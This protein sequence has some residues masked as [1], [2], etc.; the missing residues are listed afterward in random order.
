MAKLSRPRPAGVHARERLFQRLDECLEHRA[1]WVTGSA[2]AGK[3]TLI[4]SYVK[5][6]ELPALWYQVDSGDTDPAACCHY[7]KMVASRIAP[8]LAGE[9]PAL[10]AAQTP[11]MASFFRHFFR[12][13]YA[14]IGGQRFLVMDNAQE[15]L[16]AGTFRE[17]LL[18]AMHEA[19]D[20]LR[21]IVISRSLPPRDF[22]RLQANGDLA[23]LEGDELAFTEAE[24][25]AVQKLGTPAS[26]V[27][28]VEQMRKLHQLTRG[29][30][31]G[32]KLLLQVDDPD[33]VCATSGKVMGGTALFDYLA[34]EVFDRQSSSVRNFLLKVAHLPR[35]TAAMAD[36]L[37]HSDDAARILDGMY[38]DNL[39]TT[40][41]A[42]GAETHYEFHPL[43]RRFLLQRA[44]SDLPAADLAHVRRQAGALLAGSG[45]LDAAAQVL[46]SGCQWDDLQRL[47]TEH[48]PS[49][50]TRGWQRT[51]SAWLQALPQDRLAGD[52][53]FC[54]W[55]GA[56]LAPFDPPAAQV[57]LQ[58]AYQLFRERRLA[59]GCFFSW[60]AIVDLICLEWRDFSKLDYW[61]DE[62]ESLQ[63]EF[64][65]PVE[66]LHGR[67][68]ASIFSALLFRRPQDPAIH[69]WADR[70]LSV[71]EQCPDPHDRILLGCN[72]VLHYDVATGQNAQLDRLMAAID[73][74][75][76]IALTPLVGALFWGLKAMQ[77]W[78]HGQLV[79]AAA[80]AENGSRLACAN[81]LRMWDFLLGALQAYAW[82]NSGEL[83]QGRAALARL[84]KSLD[85]RRKIDVAHYHYLGCLASLLA[86]EGVQALKEI[87]NA[88]AIALVHGGPQQHALG[89]LAQAQALHALGRTDEAWPFLVRGREIGVSMRGKLICFQAD[90]CEAAF[91]L[92]EG[93]HD[94]CAKALHSAFATGAA[95]NYVNH[96]TFRP[97][98]VAR[99]CAFALAHGIEPDYTRRLIRIRDLKPPSLEADGWPWAIK[100][101]TLGRFSLVVD[102]QPVTE[103][104]RRQ[105]KPIELLQALIALGGRQI[106]IP[107][108]IESLWPDAE[109][110]GGR[111]A[112]DV[113]LSRLRH[114]LGHDDVLLLESGRVTLNPALCWVDVWAFERLLNQTRVALDGDQ[115]LDV[116]VLVEQTGA[117]LRLYQGDF[118]GREECHPWTLPPR[119][120][121]RTRLANTLA[122]VGR[123]LEAGPH[124][125]KA[126]R[127]Y[128]RA[129]EI[130]PLAEHWYRRLMIC[131]KEQGEMA[132]ALRI[133]V[134][135]CEALW[136]GLRAT[137]SQETQAIHESLDRVSGPKLQ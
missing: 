99:L 100:V 115:P 17:L 7:L 128:Q 88:N 10:A 122:D 120:R 95:E 8:P 15:A 30:V 2:G 57:R 78:S 26:R 132:E 24:S 102:D 76:G 12:T 133:Y 47:V 109:S 92:D 91:A 36:A 19:P 27:R 63:G 114:L 79:Q 110:R 68:A 56:A 85:P 106:A 58:S 50:L 83:S 90:L 74:P 66:S 13:L 14:A 37:C 97:A 104:G 38:R 107:R 81:G 72:L 70:L 55:Q 61:I 101:Y 16:C 35:M 6:R 123:S 53:W 103:T 21:L 69:L 45:E 71:I 117:L 32:L 1:L 82:L 22:A 44:R 33:A 121:L 136:V 89:S 93:N 42:V 52:P 62:A 54:Y 67:F 48:A 51:L 65:P 94:R 116:V 131:L 111:G 25:F 23:L 98:V 75:P 130:E 4:A 124:W 118:L 3:T 49:L 46:A 137:P 59:D 96:N 134:R 126:V 125:G 43:L 9:L 41:H 135:C 39:F 77:H 60:S 34:A 119:E 80:D 28:T 105:N 113:S 87:E 127:L 64:G 40:V 84:A 18:F 31:A 73:P 86:G 20:D 129:I 112:F 29:W 5:S 108:L 11:A